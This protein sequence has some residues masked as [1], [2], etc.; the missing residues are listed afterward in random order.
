MDKKILD[1]SWYEA[2]RGTFTGADYEW[3]KEFVKISAREHI[4]FN[5]NEVENPRFKCT[6]HESQEH[7]ICELEQLK[8]LIS[9]KEQNEVVKQLYM[10]RI[11]E[12]IDRLHLFEAI[13]RGDDTLFHSRS[14]ALY[15]K[16]KKSYFAY[17][18]KRMQDL[19]NQTIDTKYSDAHKRLAYV[20]SKINTV[21]A[22]AEVDILPDVV[23]DSTVVVDAKRVKEIFQETLVQYAIG[24]WDIISGVGNGRKRFSVNIAKK[25]IH[26]PDD[27]FLQ[28][29]THLLTESRVVG[30]AEHEIGVHVRR[31]HEGFKQPLKLLSLGLAKYLKGEE[32]VASYV[33]QQIDGA[34]EFY[35][36]DRYMAASLAV[37]MDGIPRDF[38]SVYTLMY[39]Y[40]LLSI[41]NTENCEEKAMHA[42]WDVCVRIFRGSSGEGVGTIFTRDIVY[43]EGNIGIWHAI[44]DKPHIFRSL[45]IGKYDP[46]NESHVNALQALEILPTW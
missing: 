1:A 30:I 36:F 40:Y 45:F 17:V 4:R 29:R 23:A 24:G 10:E 8:E 19:L 41:D 32:G 15:G 16:P 31:A 26:I 34:K 27:E 9:E 20:F 3:M 13:Q 44:A 25:L 46:L 39:D 6:T 7:L 14:I 37:G 11:E 22:I 42:A 18:A 21:K 2:L 28:Q 33:Q 35:G 12:E 5:Q 38:R 43:L